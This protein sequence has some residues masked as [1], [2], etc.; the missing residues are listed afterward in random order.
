MWVYML[1]E[2]K[3]CIVWENIVTLGFEAL[4]AMC[5]D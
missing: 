1:G 2:N 3:V 5:L 4:V